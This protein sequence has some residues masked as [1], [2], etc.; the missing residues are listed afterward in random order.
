MT[1]KSHGVGGIKAS[2]R[3][4]NWLTVVDDRLR[5]VVKPQVGAE[6]TPLGI[7]AAPA[8]VLCGL[9]GATLLGALSY[10]RSAKRM[11]QA[12]E[13][14]AAPICT[15]TPAAGVA[16]EAGPAMGSTGPTRA[17]RA[18]DF[19]TKGEIMYLFVVPGIGATALAGALGMLGRW[20]LQVDS[21]E[22][23]VRQLLLGSILGS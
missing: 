22:D 11:A 1:D 8:A 15:P 18:S 13:A 20:T 16:S 5:S 3:I 12:L 21:M 19:L 2:D 4:A 6:S 17:P 9:F 23:A 14:T 7:V 10:R